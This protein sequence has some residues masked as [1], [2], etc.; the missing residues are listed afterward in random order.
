MED[1]VD[2]IDYVQLE[3]VRNWQF[4]EHN[5]FET[6]YEL[7]INDTQSNFLLY[8]NMSKPF[9]REDWLFNLYK[10]GL[11]FTA[12]KITIFMRKLGPEDAIHLNI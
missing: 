1:F 9:P 5:L 2:E 6:K 3:D 12:D 8:T 4:L 7:E 10:L 11:E